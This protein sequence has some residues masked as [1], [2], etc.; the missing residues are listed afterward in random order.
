MKVVECTQ[1]TP[2]WFLARAGIATASNFSAVM[3]QAASGEA[4]TRRNYRTRLVV[5]RL[6]GKSLEKSF[7]SF[8]MQQGEEREPG[9]RDRYMIATGSL[10]RQVGLCVHDEL[11]CASSPDGLIDEDGGVEIKC[12]ELSA[13]FEHIRRANEPP[14]YRAQIQGNLWV[15]GRK[16]WDFV[17]FNPDFPEHLQLVVRRI[18][19]DDAY[20]AKLH[21]QVAQFMAEVRIDFNEAR[22]L[23]A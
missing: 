5:E 18:K 11:E 8:A 17:S 10:V 19:R 2:E 16:W 22:A 21:Q 7:S 13:H 9:A 15:T 4:V 6:T 3:A 12:P 23:R 14:E 1:G 20:I